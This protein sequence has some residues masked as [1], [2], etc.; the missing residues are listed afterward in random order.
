MCV[1]Y[2][3]KREAVQS[4]MVHW[5]RSWTSLKRAKGYPKMLALFVVFQPRSSKR[6]MVPGGARLY[7]C[8][9][10]R[11][12]CRDQALMNRIEGWN[13]LEEWFIISGLLKYQTR[14]HSPVTY[15]LQRAWL[16]KETIFKRPWLGVKEIN[17]SDGFERN[18]HRGRAQICH[19]NICQD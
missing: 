17:V 16:R 13:S 18:K 2:V 12:F 7:D 15:G 14:G 8:K 19:L 1:V 3:Q 11:C 5:E 10:C 4:F 9:A 6:P